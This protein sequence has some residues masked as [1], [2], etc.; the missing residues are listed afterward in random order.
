LECIFRFTQRAQRFLRD[1]LKTNP[2]FYPE[3]YSAF[4]DLNS[5]KP[6]RPL[7]ETNG[8]NKSDWS[9]V[10]FSTKLVMLMLLCSEGVSNVNYLGTRPHPL[11]RPYPPNIALHDLH[12]V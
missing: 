10:V 9:R 4:V 8:R 5:L 2:G 11:R 7:R 6:S 3:N 12:K 1:W